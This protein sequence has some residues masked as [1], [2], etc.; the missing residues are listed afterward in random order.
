MA[1]LTYT[2]SNREDVG[3]LRHATCDFAFGDDENTFVV[4]LDRKARLTLEPRALVYIELTDIGGMI[5]NCDTDTHSSIDTLQYLGLTWTGMLETHILEPDAREDYLIVSG[6]A[7]TVIGQLLA[8]LGIDDLFV[9]NDDDSGIAIQNYQF[10]RYIEAYSGIRKMLEKHGAKLCIEYSH[11]KVTLSARPVQDYSE[12]D[13]LDAEKIALKMSKCFLPVNHL[14]CLGQGDL[15]ERKVIHLYA[16]AEGNVSHTQSF[17][18]SLENALVYDYSSAEDDELLE[19]GIKKL[20]ELQACDS[21]DADFLED[22]DYDIGDIVGT[23]DTMTGDLTKATISKKIV[24]IDSKGTLNVNYNIGNVVTIK[25]AITVGS[26]GG[27][28]ASVPSSLLVR[29][30]DIESSVSNLENSLQ[31]KA[32][33]SHQHGVIATNVTGGTAND[34]RAFWAS[35]PSGLYYFNATGQLNGQPSQYGFL[36]HMVSGSEIHQL[37]HIQSN[38]ASYRRGAN[39]STESM[40]G[41]N[42][43]LD[44]SNGMRAAN[45]NGYWGLARPSDG[46]QTD[47]IRTTSAGLLPYSAG[48]P[49]SGSL[50]TSSW[51]F[52][53][54][55]IQNIYRAGSLMSDHV[56]K[57]YS[58]VPLTPGGDVGW[59]YIKFASKFAICW[60]HVTSSETAGTK[61]GN[62]YYNS[63]A[64]DGTPNYPFTF[65]E[66]PKVFATITEGAGNYFLTMLNNGTTT[67][68]PQIYIM[69]QVQRTKALS[70]TRFYLAMGYT[71]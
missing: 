46:S 67:K 11:G 44:N 38:G 40:P 31:E 50:G 17:F 4:T 63:V 58:D 33:V 25:G 57:T 37:F 7:N 26:Q 61:W 39:G 47:W 29:V 18:G 62:I 20:E 23:Y 60:R 28:G 41:W 36:E 19:E 12:T 53:Q 5:T 32:N 59:S 21:A 9:A 45:A 56:I 27:G 16:D 2:D 35:Q 54:A 43:F 8:R 65:T 34:T 42:L 51:R 70:C 30:S 66:A 3:V 22:Q 55:H 69:C 68:P 64:K 24:T 6:E 48:T 13:A 14:V 52:N 71:T 1:L 49:G 15:R 10:E